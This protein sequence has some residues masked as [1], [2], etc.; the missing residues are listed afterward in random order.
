VRVPSAQASRHRA[1]LPARG[2]RGDR[3]CRRDRRLRGVS[4]LLP[5]SVRDVQMCSL[6]RTWFALPIDAMCG[7]NE[8][9]WAEG[10]GYAIMPEC[11]GEMGRERRRGPGR[12]EEAGVGDCRDARAESAE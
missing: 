6:P 8:R 11:E 2:I 5:L 10:S 1:A 3:C 9:Q 12:T 4:P 7:C